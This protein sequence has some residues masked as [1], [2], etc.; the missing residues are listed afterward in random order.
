MYSWIFLFTFTVIIEAKKAKDHA[1]R[2]LHRISNT[3]YAH[4]CPDVTSLGFTNEECEILA[5]RQRATNYLFYLYTD[6]GQPVT[7]EEKQG[8][9]RSVNSNPESSWR[10]KSASEQSTSKLVAC[11]ERKGDTSRLNKRVCFS[12]LPRRKQKVEKL[13]SPA[14][15]ASFAEWQTEVSID[16]SA[17]A[18]IVRSLNQHLSPSA[19]LERYLI[20]LQREGYL[21][22]AS[23]ERRQ[24]VQIELDRRMTPK[25]VVSLRSKF[26]PHPPV[27]LFERAV[28]DSPFN[29][30]T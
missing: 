19:R 2:G 6:R 24:N 30:C 20:N 14:R 29:K 11:L 12:A 28:R 1:S 26:L 27:Y 15:R 22:S 9:S 23:K 3:G 17:G 18:T 10:V 13:T 5:S 7:R 16:D 4:S 21:T 25:G 8:S